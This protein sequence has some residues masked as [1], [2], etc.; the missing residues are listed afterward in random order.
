MRFRKDINALR[1]VAVTLVALFH[2]QASHFHGGFAGVDVFFV[3]SGY[4]MTAI[5]VGKLDVGRFR[6]WDFY[7]ARFTRI[8]PALVGVSAALLVFGWFYLD[9]HSYKLLAKHAG[10]SITFI[11][12]FVYWRE[13]GYFDASSQS[14]WLLHTWSLSTEWQFYLI[15][16]IVLMAG[17]RLFGARRPVFQCLLAVMGVVSFAL[18][19]VVVRAHPEANFFLL[20][21]RA[22]EMIIG[23]FV[24]LNEDKLKLSKLGATAVQTAGLVAIMIAGLF[25]TD[26][27]DWPGYYTVV[28]V[29]GAAL[30]VL[31]NA[32]DSFFSTNKPLQLLGR[33]SYSIY[34]WHWPVVVLTHYL[35]LNTRD[36]LVITSGLACSVVLGWLSYEL[37]ERRAAGL[38]E[39]FGP[40]GLGTLATAPVVVI[41]AC[42][43][44]GFANGA[45]ARLSPEVKAV[46]AESSDVD[47]RRTECL[48]DSVHRLDSP[49]SEIGCKYGASPKVGAIVWGDSHGNAVITSVAQS[50]AQSNESVMFYGTSGCP[51]FAG[52]SRFGKHTEEPCRRFAS[53]VVD[54][55]RQYPS[56]VPLV[57]VARFSAYVDGKNN[58]NDPTI[59]IGYNGTRPSGD[60]V[61]RRT[62]YSS[63]LTHDLCELAQTRPTYVLLPIPEMDHNVPDYLSR[64]LILGQHPEDVSITEDAYN[65]RNVTAHAAIEQ[66]AQQCGVKVLDPTPYLC[67]D[68]RCYGSDSLIP[69]YIDGDHLS[70]RGSARLAPLF[71]DVFHQAS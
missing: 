39:R 56:T 69:L 57:V 36:P 43:A 37:V 53:K 20:P 24:M 66:A 52:A 23:G 62:L 35:D 22:W 16:P 21:T 9:P 4:L 18:M 14:K 55:L 29:L 10:S 60:P 65:L 44:I 45:S 25:F 50:A 41:A 26:G 27:L 30:V 6:L 54:D 34:L 61:Q 13:S 38:R 49:G 19:P 1:G 63:F 47:P 70:R 11:S 68:G 33:W 67:R 42:A 32:N 40:R 17:A 28:P 48:V 7:L 12:N 71:R 31:A 3:I 15:Y 8:V 51:P 5:V 64:R 58:E 2:F 59:L 46:S